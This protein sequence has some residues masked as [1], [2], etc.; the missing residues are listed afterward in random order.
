MHGVG[1]C[2]AARHGVSSSFA[3][4][5][6]LGSTSGSRRWLTVSATLLT[7][8][9]VWGVVQVFRSPGSLFSTAMQGSAELESQNLHR[10]WGNSKF[11]P[12]PCDEQVHSAALGWLSQLKKLLALEQGL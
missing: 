10:L 3:A 6:L 8:R 1:F 11:A 5:T 7:L 2:R 4:V 9:L 12:S